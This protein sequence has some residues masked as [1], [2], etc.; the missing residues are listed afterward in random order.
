MLAE[1]IA[2]KLNEKF[3]IGTVIL[4]GMGDVDFYDFDDMPWQRDLFVSLIAAELEPLREALADA[5]NVL[6]TI[7][8]DCDYGPDPAVV[9][10]VKAALLL[11][12]GEGQ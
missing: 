5:D 4:I 7:E 9:A 3:D 1:K 11:I 12:D 10:E 2:E 8:T 6:S